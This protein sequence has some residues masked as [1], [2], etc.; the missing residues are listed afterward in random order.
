MKVLL[1][2]E[3]ETL[4]P[5]ELPGNRLSLDMYDN[6]P[7]PWNISKPVTEFPQ[8]EY[9]KLEYDRD[10]KLS[11]GVSF[12]G[13]SQISTMDELEKGLGTASM[14]TR[15]RAANPDLVG[16]DKDVV[17]VFIKELREALGG[18]EWMEHGTGTAI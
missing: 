13:Q 4:A 12:F 14:V 15:W 9:I 5:Y 10:G 2:V 3:R 18:Q 11:N 6:L 17:K 8:S 1:R 7:L 16:T